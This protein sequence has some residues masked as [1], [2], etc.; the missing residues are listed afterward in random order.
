MDGFQVPKKPVFQRTFSLES[1]HSTSFPRDLP[2]TR[3][4]KE[5]CGILFDRI[6][7]QPK[8]ASNLR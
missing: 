7:L 4:I 8:L 1:G 3:P 6:S 5:I 2:T